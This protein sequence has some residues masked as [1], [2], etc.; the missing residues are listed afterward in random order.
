MNRQDYIN[1]RMALFVAQDWMQN[2]DQFIVNWKGLAKLCDQADTSKFAAAPDGSV[3]PGI[4]AVHPGNDG[5]YIGGDGGRYIDYIDL[6]SNIAWSGLNTL[7]L[8]INN[9]QWITLIVPNANQAPVTID[10][11]GSISAPTFSVHY[12]SLT[13]PSPP[14]GV[15]S[16]QITVGAEF[17]SPY[18]M[19][20]DPAG[21]VYVA[22]TG[23][24]RVEKATLSPYAS[25]SAPQSATITWA[26][27]LFD[28]G[29]AISRYT[30][31]AAD[32]TAPGQRRPDLHALTG[33]GDDVHDHRSDP[34]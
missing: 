28:R 34:K 17:S 24:N 3:L 30:V 4:G 20:V 5:S 2:I 1:K 9:G 22:D 33:D 31:T 21:N 7:M 23:N 29:P 14:L 19:A 25:S 8:S 15:T 10:V 11:S 18:G 16:S 6:A 32:L 26:A 12:I 13:F 27:P